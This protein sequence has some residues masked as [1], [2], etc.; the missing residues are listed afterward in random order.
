MCFPPR[1]CRF[2]FLFKESKVCRIQVRTLKIII[3]S[4]RYVCALCWV[5]IPLIL[6]L[7]AGNSNTAST[8]FLPHWDAVPCTLCLTPIKS[9][10]QHSEDAGRTINKLHWIR[11]TWALQHKNG[12]LMS[13]QPPSPVPLAAVT[14][15]QHSLYLEQ[16]SLS[17]HNEVRPSVEIGWS[18]KGNLKIMLVWVNPDKN[19]GNSELRSL[20]AWSPTSAA[21]IGVCQGTA[22]PEVFALRII[23]LNEIFLFILGRLRM[24]WDPTPWGMCWI[25][26]QERFWASNVHLHAD[27]DFLSYL[28]Y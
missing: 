26:S 24:A 22:S 16:P 15:E 25:V 20:P 10:T 6:G 12:L 21:C 9:D 1:W 13:C 27:A 17:H 7:Y 4:Q 11:I 3:I 8:R 23:R 2:L 28:L 5:K 19:Q 18:T 14:L